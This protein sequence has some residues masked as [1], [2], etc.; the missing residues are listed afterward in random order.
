LAKRLF[1][2]LGHQGQKNKHFQNKHWFVGLAAFDGK[3]NKNHLVFLDMCGFSAVM[4]RASKK[5]LGQT[6]NSG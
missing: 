3:A 4:P 2:G 1:G 5:Q 6:Q